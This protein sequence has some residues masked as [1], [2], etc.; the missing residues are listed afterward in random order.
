MSNQDL[1]END[2]NYKNKIDK[3]INKI[4]K[5]IKIK[6]NKISS[7]YNKNLLYNQDNNYSNTNK[8]NVVVS[9]N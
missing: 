4:N 6:K 1:I 5:C 3:R 7:I 9:F 8:I 2:M